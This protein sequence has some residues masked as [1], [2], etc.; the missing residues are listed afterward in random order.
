MVK[1]YCNPINIEYK[2]Q[3]YG[4]SA[5]REAADP[6]LVY[7]KDKYYLFA[8]MSAG[9]FY[10]DDLINWKWHENREL[11]IY[12]YAPDVRQIEDYLYLS[13]SDRKP[14]SIWRTREPLNNQ[15]ELV[16]KPFPFWDPNIFYDDD[17]KVYLFWGC[18]NS[19]PL[20]GIELDN[21]TFMP[22]GEKVPVIYPNTEEHGFERFFYPGKEP[23][24]K[25]GSLF[26]RLIM[27]ALNW[28]GTPYM[29]GLYCNKWDGKYYLQYAAPATQYPVYGD[30]V[31][32]A[33]KPLGPYKYQVHN[34]FSFKPTGFIAGAGHGSTIEDKYGNLWHASTMRIS[35]NAN[36][37]RRLGLFP[38][39]RDKDGIL[40]CNQNFADY[41]FVV[42]DGKFDPCE[43]QPHHMLLSYKK[44]A[45]AS[46]ALDGHGVELALNEDIQTWWCA[47]GSGGEWYQVDL[48]KGYSV[49]SVQIN[50]AEESIPVQKHPKSECSNDIS[51]GHRYIDSSQDL[52][53]RYIME[54]STDGDSWF[55]IKDA[56]GTE[57]DLSHDYVVLH[58]NMLVRFIKVT[59]IELPYGQKYAISGLRV[60]GLDD[61]KKPE[62]VGSAQ[63]IFQDPMTAMVTWKKIQSAIGYN[64]RYGIAPDKLFTSYLIYENN[65]VLLTALNKG[66]NY[67]YCIDSFN[68]S[69][70]TEG[71]TFKLQESK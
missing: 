24:K 57:S 37:E 35:I 32:I 19:N 64:V 6:T 60:F 27:T 22:I 5:H 7:F 29:E 26:M 50:F 40:F 36:F 8:S 12:L 43:L 61:G 39:G 20:Y 48:G 68:E 16:S 33:E 62:I 54:G 67:W 9:F 71:E 58:K 56:S 70:V 44:K 41:P 65:Q 1:E 31:Y 52:C 18:G 42:P 63:V 47:A 45:M 15:F 30:G 17:G 11:E 69:G 21:N 46:S 2:F 66:I 28:K 55:F 23:E 53:T 51:T 25:S 4:C 13:A 34:P 38:A 3:H 14:T 10:S 49:H 59:A